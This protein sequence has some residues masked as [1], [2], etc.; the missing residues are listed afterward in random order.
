[1]SQ[2]SNQNAKPARASGRAAIAKRPSI[3]RAPAGAWRARPSL[4]AYLATPYLTPPAAIAI[5]ARPPRAIQVWPFFN[6]LTPQVGLTAAQVGLATAQVG[7]T[8]PHRDSKARQD[9]PK[10]AQDT[11]RAS[12]T[13]PKSSKTDPKRT[14]DAPQKAPR[15][16]RDT[17]GT[18]RISLFL[19]RFS[20][21]YFLIVPSNPPK[22]AQNDPNKAQERP[23][24]TPGRPKTALRRPPQA[25]RRSQDAP[26]GFQDAPGRPTRPKTLPRASMTSTKNGSKMPPKTL[27]RGPKPPPDP[28]P[29]GG[30][31]NH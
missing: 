21:I 8:T 13:P 19:F 26:K 22:T 10:T 30:R 23:E 29:D 14:Q 4:P 7:L 12:K 6:F 25:P 1:M 9:A 5:T 20:N 27:P 16:L 2:G 3:R 17:A 18:P 31:A 24:R 11:P 15:R 28:P